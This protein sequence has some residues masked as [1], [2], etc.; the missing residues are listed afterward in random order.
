MK[1]M[2]MNEDK[3][4][5]TVGISINK[6]YIKVTFPYHYF[7]DKQEKNFEKIENSREIFK[8][9]YLKDEYKDIKLLIQV[10]LKYY[11]QKGESLKKESK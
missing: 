3:T 8:D 2:K 1:V 5:D 9:I 7:K 4:S 11:K 10:F 6:D